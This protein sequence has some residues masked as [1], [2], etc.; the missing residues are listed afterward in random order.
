MTFNG[1]LYGVP[2]AIENIALIRNTDLVPDAPATI[3]DLVDG[4]QGAQGRRQGQRD[5][6]RSRSARRA[7]RTTSTRCSP[8]PAARCSAPPPPATRT[9]R[10]STV[11][12]PESIA[13]FEKIK[14]LGEKGD[15]AL[16]TLDRRRERHPAVHRQEGAVPDLRPVGHRR[17]QEGRRRRTTSPPIPPFAGGK[18]ARPFI[19]VRLLR[20]RPRARTRRSP[21]SSSR[22]SSTNADVPVA[23]Y[24]AEP[25]PAGADRRRSTRSRRP[26]RTS[27]SSSTPARTAR[28]CPAIPA[29]GEVWGPFGNAEAAIVGGGDV[30][31]TARRRRQG[32][33][34]RDQ[35]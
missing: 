15:G 30:K 16:K 17:H 31:A 5:H 34:R 19:G 26:T 20:R 1:Q 22:T 28:S 4:R 33:P 14:A 11:D 2:Y 9:R 7:T 8:R 29:M 3:E 12:T 27:A 25:A 13:A 24:E 35:Q 6:V 18:P 21:R 10:T 32:D 23:L